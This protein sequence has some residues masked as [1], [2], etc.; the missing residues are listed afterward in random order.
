MH[1]KEQGPGTRGP[2]SWLGFVALMSLATA[3]GATEIID[4]V[5][6]IVAGQV[7]TLS[8]V[9]AASELGL[10]NTAGSTDLIATTLENLVER[11]LILGEVQRYQ[12]PEP[13]PAVIEQRFEIVRARAGSPDAFRSALDTGGISEAR[14]RE[15]VRDDLRIEAYIEQRFGV[16]AQP[17]DEEVMQYYREHAREFARDGLV[18]GFPEIRDAIR[19]RLTSERRRALIAGWV[20]DL[21][22]RGDVTTLY[23]PGA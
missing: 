12:P 19:V 9:R 11:E 5:L 20:A 15:F 3:S 21:R 17:T 4:R 6:A 7:I 8:D 2:L 13:L 18:P 10:V 23:L 22:R 16:A 14:L 1:S